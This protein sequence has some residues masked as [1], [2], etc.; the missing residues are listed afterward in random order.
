MHTS[1]N[2]LQELVSFCF[3]ILP[4]HNLY[5]CHVISFFLDLDIAVA[6]DFHITN[7]KCIRII[8]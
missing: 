4:T 8:M 7:A 3:L 6:V 2:V 5:S 1:V